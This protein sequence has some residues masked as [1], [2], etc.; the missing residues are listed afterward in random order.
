[1]KKIDFI[2]D[3]IE[4]GYSVQKITDD[5]YTFTINNKSYSKDFFK[6]LYYNNK[7]EFRIWNVETKPK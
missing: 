6:T 1:M 2:M 7:N 4:Q 5:T 3:K